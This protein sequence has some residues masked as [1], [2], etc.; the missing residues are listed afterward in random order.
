M[1]KVMI[2]VVIEVVSLWWTFGT[3]TRLDVGSNKAPTLTVLPPSSEELSKETTASLLCLANQGF[4]SDWTIS[5]KVDGKS[6]NHHAS[7]PV[8]EKDGLYTWSSTLTLTVQEWTKAET[9]ICEAHQT[10][11]DP[12]TQTLR[13]DDCS[14]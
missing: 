8:L 12:V 11:Q 13:K 6:Q 1:S 3:G 2:V 4:P 9:V 5:W 14:G 7:R 10:S